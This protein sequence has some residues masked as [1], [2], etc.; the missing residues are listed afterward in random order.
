M[1]ASEFFFFLIFL[2]P[3]YRD[4]TYDSILVE[5]KAESFCLSIISFGSAVELFK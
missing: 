5:K 4:L 2:K 3:E 1:A